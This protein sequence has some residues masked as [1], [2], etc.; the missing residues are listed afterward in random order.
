VTPTWRVWSLMPPECLEIV[1][2]VSMLDA[3]RAWADRQF[4]KGMMPRSGTEVLVC[5]E[6][7]PQP[8]Q[9]AYRVKITIVNA[10]AFRAT[11]SGPA[12]EGLNGEPKGGG[13]G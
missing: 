5:C 1:S 12:F 2:S 13:R 7:D 6:N 11:L 4:R 3:A 9:S 10:P 8:R